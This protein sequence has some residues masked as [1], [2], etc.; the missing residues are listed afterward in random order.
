MRC[1]QARLAAAPG[2]SA[3]RCLPLAEW[4]KGTPEAAALGCCIHGLVGPSAPARAIATAGD[5]QVARRRGT[6]IWGTRPCGTCQTNGG[7]T[8]GTHDAPASQAKR[9]HRGA[10]R[11]LRMGVYIHIHIHIH[12]HAQRA[13]LLGRAA[14]AAVGACKA[15]TRGAPLDSHSSPGLPSVN[16]C[17]SSSAH[18]RARDQPSSAV[19]GAGWTEP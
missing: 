11:A 1:P 12:I 3:R 5:R 6:G 14:Y 8:S 7:R 2:L 4:T 10:R 13:L 19:S 16:G 15:R 17:A 9:G 18:A